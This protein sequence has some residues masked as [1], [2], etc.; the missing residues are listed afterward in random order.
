VIAR[1]VSHVE[2]DETYDLGDAKLL[3]P[4][5]HLSQLRSLSAKPSEGGRCNLSLLPAGLVE[6]AV[7]GP[8]EETCWE[9]VQDATPLGRFTALTSL[10]MDTDFGAGASLGLLTRLINLKSLNIKT[11]PAA[12]GVVRTLTSLT[13]LTWLQYGESRQG[14]TMFD[15]MAHLTGLSRLRFVSWDDITHHS[16]ECIAHLTRLSHL[17]MGSR[18][19]ADCAARS[20]L[21]PLTGLVSLELECG[22][23]GKELLSCLNLEAFNELTAHNV[24]GPIHF[25]PRAGG[26]TRLE[27]HCDHRGSVEELETMI[28]GMTNLQDLRLYGAGEH[29]KLDSILHALTKLTRLDYEGSL[30]VQGGFVPS[31]D[32]SACAALPCLRSLCL[33]AH[34]EVTCACLPALQAM[35][36]LSHLQLQCTDIA[37]RH[38]TPEVIAGFN[39]ERR[40]RGWPDLKIECSWAYYEGPLYHVPSP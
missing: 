19:L 38:L 17:N 12:I 28:A 11:C 27:L 2:L 31:R 25:L 20:M 26:L 5:K 8:E 6:L 24:Q 23:V 3:A 4:L 40:R 13:S 16:L 39:A 22:T 18:S 15:D 10:T 30:I 32:L 1:Y 37:S 29:F 33:L 14:E 21:V 7:R 35:T 9:G 36:G 34:L